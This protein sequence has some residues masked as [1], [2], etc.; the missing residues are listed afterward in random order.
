MWEVRHLRSLRA[1]FRSQRCNG[2]LGLTKSCEPTGEPNARKTFPRGRGAGSGAAAL[3]AQTADRLK[4][5]AAYREVSR[6][7]SHQL[8]LPALAD[9]PQPPG[10]GKPRRWMHPATAAA[11]TTSDIEDLRVAQPGTTAELLAHP[12][13]GD[14]RGWLRQAGVGTFPPRTASSDLPAPLSEA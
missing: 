5:L 12:A 2:G 6:Q 14:A 4:L 9:A 1:N 11:Q 13:A 3:A 7:V 10:G 8:A